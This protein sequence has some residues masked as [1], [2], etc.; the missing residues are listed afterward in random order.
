LWR[1]TAL[2]KASATSAAS[3]APSGPTS[4]GTSRAHS[5]KGY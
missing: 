4:I 1:A 5:P 2:T 3:M